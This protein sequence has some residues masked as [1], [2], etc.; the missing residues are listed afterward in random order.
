MIPKRPP[1]AK[2]DTILKAVD[3]FNIMEK[4]FVVAVRGYYRDTMGK[5]GVNDRGLYDDAIFLC[6]PDFFAGYNANVDPGGYRKGQGFGS[7]KGMARLKPGIYRSHI[8]GL[9]RGEYKALVQR[10]APVTVIRDGVNGEYEHTGYHGINIHRGGVSSVSSIGCLT[11]PPKQWK[12]FISSAERLMK[13]ERQI[14]MPLVL[15]EERI[16]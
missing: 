11:I 9:H 7:K 12:D 6:G 8:L 4:V 13:Q 16:T 14:V 5:P 3:Q 2:F 15:T 10:A 1:Q